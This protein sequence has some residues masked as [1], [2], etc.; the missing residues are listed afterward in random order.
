MDGTLV[1]VGAG[2]GKGGGGSERSPGLE[3]DCIGRGWCKGAE[4]FVDGGFS[5][6]W[7]GDKEVEAGEIDGNCEEVGR[8]GVDGKAAG[9]GGLCG[10]EGCDKLEIRDGMIGGT[11][12]GANFKASGNRTCDEDARFRKGS[13]ASTEGSIGW[14]R[15]CEKAGG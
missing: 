9:V 7:Y 3:L 6:E 10:A 2:G 11:L 12:S 8:D 14:I 1:D 15:G 13:T 4:E 5:V